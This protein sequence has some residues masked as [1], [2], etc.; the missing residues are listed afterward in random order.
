ME[1]VTSVPPR[2]RSLV[3][4]R[5]KA[6]APTWAP[7]SSAKARS[8]CSCPWTNSSQYSLRNCGVWKNV[9]AGSAIT[10][11][12]QSRRT[13]SRPSSENTISMPLAVQDEDGV[14][15]G[16]EGRPHRP[17]RLDVGDRDVPLLEQRR[18][19]LDVS[20]REG[21]GNVVAEVQEPIPGGVECA[22]QLGIRRV[23]GDNHAFPGDPE[24][25]IE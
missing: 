22:V 16:A 17:V 4:E 15:V 14:R 1:S 13:K 3:S 18:P 11:F 10:R 6:T 8:S 19:L 20:E 21:R 9:P 25:L 23:L 12:D 7:S 2:N 5:S 24:G